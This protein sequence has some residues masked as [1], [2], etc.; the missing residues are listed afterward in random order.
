VKTN[1]RYS[2]QFTLRFWKGSR[3][4]PLFAGRFFFFFECQK[5]IELIIAGPCI[6]FHLFIEILYS[7]TKDAPE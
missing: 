6:H 2:L 7:F 5:F 4:L 3:G 1:E